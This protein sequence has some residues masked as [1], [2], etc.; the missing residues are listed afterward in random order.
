MATAR[1]VSLVLVFLV[2]IAIV[3]GM[4]SVQGQISEAVQQ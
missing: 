1:N 3:A 4:Y 2:I